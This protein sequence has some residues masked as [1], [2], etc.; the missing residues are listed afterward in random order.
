[1]FE[2]NYRIVHS[3]YD[4]FIGQNGFFQINCNT[5]N[6][7]EIYPKK[8]EGIMDKVSLYDWFERIIKVTKNL[9]TEDY[10]VLSDVESYN[11]WIEFQR[12]KQ[13]V[14]ISIIKAEKK[15]NSHDIEFE[16]EESSAGEW[17]NQVV[18]YNQLRNEVIKKA[19]EYIKYISTNNIDNVEVDKIKKKFEEIL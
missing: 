8:L 14:V 2:L 11:T 4:D 16:L 5:Y 1:M 15:Q 17:V 12:R 3:E 19:K 10:V 6:Y 18:C 13:E 7:G 9:N